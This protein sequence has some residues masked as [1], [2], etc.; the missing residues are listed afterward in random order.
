MLLQIHD[1][2]MFE[3]HQDDLVTCVKLVS[4]WMNSDNWDI[5]ERLRVPTPVNISVGPSWGSLVPY[6]SNVQ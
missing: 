5:A 4:K 6:K 3:V 1:E 2:L